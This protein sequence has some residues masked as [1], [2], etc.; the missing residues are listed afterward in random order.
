MS[1]IRK[2]DWDEFVFKNDGRNK[3]N[4]GKISIEMLINV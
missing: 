1:R 2:E 3:M 4:I